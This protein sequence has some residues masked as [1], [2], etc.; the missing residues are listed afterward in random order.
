MV[1]LLTSM[2]AIHGG[3]TPGGFALPINEPMRRVI[4]VLKRGEE[5]DYG[6]LGVAFDDAKGNGGV[7]LK[8]IGDNTPAKVDGKLMVG[9]VLLAVNGVPIHESDDTFLLIGRQLAGAKVKLTV[10]RGGFERFAEVTLAK[11][12]VPGKRIASSTGSRPFVRGL[13]ASIMRASSCSKSRAGCRFPG[14]C[15]SAPVQAD[16]RG[17][18]ANAQGRR[19]HH[20]REPDSRDDAGR[21]LS[22]GRRR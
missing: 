9:D 2:A 21:L 7:I 17:R 4:D 3:E 8:S 16:K 11:L 18:F 1:G 12:Y 20:A 19:C 22:S 15:S 13:C 10:R 6:F 5:V 14:A